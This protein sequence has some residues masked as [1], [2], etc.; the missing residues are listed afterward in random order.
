[1][2]NYTRYPSLA[3][4]T[5]IITGGASGI[6]EEIVRAFAAN[7]AR[8]AFLDLER[9]LGEKLARAIESEGAAKP[10]FLPCDLLDVASVRAALARARSELGP[11]SALINNA[12]NDLRQKFEEVTPEQFDWMMRVNVGHVFFASQAV[13]PQMRELGSGSIVNL[14]SIAWMLGV[15]SLEA[16]SAG[17][18]AVLGFTKSLARELGPD[19]I[20]VNAI[21]PGLVLTEKQRRLWFADDEKLRK[22]LAT[23]CIPEAIQ[24]R[25]IARMALFLASDDSQMITKQCFLVDAGTH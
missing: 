8:V 9:D 1:M 19:R 17:K 7:Q 10:L 25:E 24:P 22:H 18:A 4:K 11:A 2:T 3:G 12:A 13:V 15:V 20:R 14:S 23:Q 16:Y 21:A 5:V 6:G